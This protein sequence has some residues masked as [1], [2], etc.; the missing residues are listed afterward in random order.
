MSGATTACREC[1]QVFQRKRATAAFCSS[2]HRSQFHNRAASR[3]ADLFHLFMSWRFDRAAARKARAWSLMCR[4][5]ATYAAEDAERRGGR[6]SYETVGE[7]LA[8][9]SHINCTL[10][11]TNITGVKRRHG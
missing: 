1:G 6:P 7:V 2:K 4:L 11:N 9:N 3:G 10:V 5:A 8:R